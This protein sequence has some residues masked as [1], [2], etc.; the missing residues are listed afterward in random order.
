M[1]ESLRGGKHK[2]A[3]DSCASI[4]KACNGENPCSEC[5]HRGRP[6]TYQRLYEDI[7]GPTSSVRDDAEKN[8]PKIDASESEMDID[9][10]AGQ[11]GPSGS[12]W[13]LGLQN[14]YP[15]RETSRIVY[16]RNNFGT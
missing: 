12:A 10:P 6:C 11:T 4:R 7:D 1:P 13:E 14:F 9:D 16:A 5:N 15:S 8:D 2:R 3:C